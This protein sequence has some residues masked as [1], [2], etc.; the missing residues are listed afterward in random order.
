MAKRIA[1]G[2]T[3]SRYPFEISTPDRFS[4]TARLLVGRGAGD[5][6]NQH[7]RCNSSNGSLV[8]YETPKIVGVSK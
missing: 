8:V 5:I 4:I 7:S 1:E 2:L 6:R 3:W